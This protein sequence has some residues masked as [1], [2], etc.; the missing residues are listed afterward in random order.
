MSKT[1]PKDQIEEYKQLFKLFD[2]NRD[3][4]VTIKEFKAVLKQY[5]IEISED[6]LKKEIKR[7]DQTNDCAIS[8]EEF[9]NIMTNGH[10]RS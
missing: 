3:G 4:H 8:F 2:K 6:V 1:L 9:L 5:N 10:G 7:Y